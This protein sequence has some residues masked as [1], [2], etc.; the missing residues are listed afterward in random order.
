MHE[1][2]LVLYIW[3]QRESLSAR[4]QHKKEPFFWFLFASNEKSS[5]NCI[6]I[7]GNDHKRSSL[8]WNHSFL[9]WFM[10]NIYAI[11]PALIPRR[12]EIEFSW[13]IVQVMLQAIN[14]TLLSHMPHCFEGVRMIFMNRPW[15]IHVLVM[16]MHNPFKHCVTSQYVFKQRDVIMLLRA[17]TIVAA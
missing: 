2:T 12:T 5:R 17:F 4:S 6:S 1:I 9:Q 15:A 16:N 8:W 10:N 14:N 7:F 13:A 3:M 11:S